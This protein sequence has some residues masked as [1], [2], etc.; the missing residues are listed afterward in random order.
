[1]MKRTKNF[2][3]SA[4]VFIIPPRPHFISID[5]ADDVYHAFDS[6]ER[7]M[8]DAIDG[9][10]ILNE[11]VTI[12]RQGFPPRLEVDDTGPFGNPF[13]PNRCPGPPPPDFD[14]CNGPP[15]RAFGNP[16]DENQPPS[17]PRPSVRFD[18]CFFPPSLL[19]S[20]F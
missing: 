6:F 10:D 5:M 13:D 8:D 20:T 3:F 15:P 2:N 9:L 1:M 12:K 4:K 14:Q 19:Q 16:I 11:A 17:N 7:K 18:C